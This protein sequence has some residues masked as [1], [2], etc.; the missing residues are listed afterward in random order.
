MANMLYNSVELPVIPADVL[1]EYPYAVISY[2]PEAGAASLLV[3]SKPLHHKTYTDGTDDMVEVTNTGVCL[4]YSY[5]PNG[6]VVAESDDWSYLMRISGQP[7]QYVIW[8]NHDVLEAGTDTVW[9]AASEPV[10]VAEDIQI[11]IESGTSLR[12]LT[13]GKYCDRNI[14]VTA[15]GGGGT[16]SA[17]DDGKGNVTLLGVTATNSGNGNI[18]VAGQE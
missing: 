2:V 5:D 3:G 18:T 17:T 9:M 4:I 8:S 11:E 14:L 12:L 1:V 10:P 13:S 6:A 7:S 15:T 16:I